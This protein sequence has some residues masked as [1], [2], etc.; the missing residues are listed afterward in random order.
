MCN[1]HNGALDLNRIFILI[2]IHFR[3]LLNFKKDLSIGYHQIQITVHEPYYR[4]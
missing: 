4:K 1:A 2:K 3:L